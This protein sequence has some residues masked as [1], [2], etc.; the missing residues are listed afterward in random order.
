MP[1]A[2]FGTP[3]QQK[4]IHASIGK[5]RD[6]LVNLTGS[7]R[8][9]N[10]KPSKTGSLTVV[11]PAPA[12][13]LSRRGRWTFRALQPKPSDDDT[14]RP[15]AQ[16]PGFLDVD[17]A[18]AEL[19][20]V[21]RSLYRRSTQAYLDQG[22]SVL[23]LAFGT[24]A[25]RDE[26][27][28]QYQSPLLLVPV[29]LEA[30]TRDLPVLLPT[31]EDTVINPA[32]ALQLEQFGI[33]L[34]AVDQTQA[35]DVALVEMLAKVDTAVGNRAGWEVTPNLVL[36]CFSFAKEA[37]YQDLK[38]NE[39]R[40]A[41]HPA[42]GAL[43]CGGTE[44]EGTEF[45]FDEIRDTEIDHRAA[46]EDTHVIM[47]AD[48]SQRACVAAALSGRSFVMDG[49]PGTGKSQT[50]ANM[51]G[52]LLHAGK[53]VL[54]VSEKA[55]ALD[56]VRDRLDEAG[57]RPYLFEL[58][59]KK[60][61]RKEVA[62]ELGRALDTELV[63]PAS[64]AL[65]ELDAVRR[66]RE[67]LNAYADAMNRQRV[68]LGLSLHDVLGTIAQLSDVPT[69]PAPG[70]VIEHLTVDTLG[71]IGST[72][73][74]LAAAW[75]PALQGLSFLWR[76]LTHDGPMDSLLYQAA[77]ALR[78]LRATVQVNGE[79]AS[80]AELTHPRQ[81]QRLA[82]LLD[83]LS[84]RPA[85]L[86]DNWITAPS[87]EPVTE[88][89]NALDACLTDIAAREAD[90][91]HQ[92]G[93]PWVRIPPPAVL[94]EITDLRGLTP[95]IDIDHLD[96][97]QLTAL[98]ASLSSSAAMLEHR[99]TSLAAL[100]RTLGLNDP[101]D[102]ATARDLL[103]VGLLAEAPQ[104]PERRWLSPSG[105]N[106]VS[107]ALDVLRRARDA[108]AA[109]ETAATRYFT[110]AALG[111]DVASL[112]ERFAARHGLSKL[113]SDYR[114]DKRLLASLS[115]EG[116]SNDIARQHLP[117]AVEWKNAAAAFDAAEA[118]HSA[119]IGEYYDGRSTDFDAA[120]SA[121]EIARAAL[122]LT[123]DRGQGQGQ[124]QDLG[125]VAEHLSRQTAPLA[126]VL[127]M[128]HGI[129]ADLNAW[130][131]ALAPGQAELLGGSIGHAIGWL[132]DQCSALPAIAA[133]TET[134]STAA[135][136]PLTFAQARHLVLLRDRA[137]AAHSWLDERATGFSDT[138]S[139]L[140]DGPRTDIAAVRA[141]IEWARVLRGRFPA[142]G[143]LTPA[144]VKAT[145][146]AIRTDNL[147]AAADAWQRARAV[148]LAAFSG[149]RGIEL[150]A[151]LDDY[152]EARGLIEAL[153]ED[154]GGPGEWHAYQRALGTLYGHGLDVTVAFCIAER[155]PADQLAAVIQRALLQEWAEHQLR[156]DPGLRT[157]RAQDRDVLV[158]EYRKLDRALISAATGQI[159][160]ACNSRRPKT[161]IGEA[162]VIRREAE[163]KK[164]HMPVRTLIEKTR[165]V[166][167]AIKPCFMMSPLS[168][169]QFLPHDMRFNVVIFDEASQ[170]SP[171]DAINCVYR[172]DAL[173]LA[174]DQK[175]LPPTSFFAAAAPDDG[176]EWSEDSAD[177]A[178]FESVLDLAKS[179]GVF[180]NLTLRWHY[181]SR[182]E[183]LIAFSNVSFYSGRLVTFPGARADGPDVGV[184]LFHVEG[185]YRRGSTR[186]N[187]AE[188]AAVAERVIHHFDT[189]PGM[190]L[191][192]VTF[193]EAQ[194]TAVDTVL[195]EARATRPDL[196]RF[197]DSDDRLN[198]FF[199]K[200]LETVQGD[201]RDVLIFSVG[202]GPDENGKITMNFGPLN[203]Q[204]GWRRLNV[205]ITRA[206]YRNEVVSS[207]RAGDIPESVTSPGIRHLRRYLDYAERGMAAL[208][209]E[210]GPGG[211]AESPFEESVIAVIRSWGYD[212]MPQVGTA[213]YRIDIGV[214][215]PGS[216]GAYA[217]GVE[218]DGYHYHSSRAARDRDRLREQVLRG[219]GWR[220]HRIWGTAW[221]R[222]RKGAEHQLRTAIE[223]AIAAPV[224]GLLTDTTPGPVPRDRPIVE[225]TAATFEEIPS[226]TRPYVIVG[227]PPLPN[228]MDPGD[229]G[230]R[231]NMIEP[232][233]SIVETEGPVHI[234]VLH[235]RLRAAWNIG[236]VGPRIR[237]NIDAA[238]RNANVIR[239][240]DF[241]TDSGPLPVIVRTPVRGCQREI[242]HIHDRELEEALMRL[243]RDAGSISREDLTTAVARIYGWSRRGPDISARMNE[244]IRR[245][246]NTGT[247]SGDEYALTVTRK[248]S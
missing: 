164:R 179:S 233:R 231:F 132:R 106:D 16:A 239:Q 223:E 126:G 37:M 82:D 244:L 12:E 195:R 130:Q 235:E 75:R 215:H 178:D 31:D 32:L 232:I 148:L 187:P 213:G 191:G 23:Y 49:P 73:T 117:L 200:N 167:Q 90:A 157:T 172:G 188:A 192:V 44:S 169:S 230:T 41:R 25:W 26:S 48:S 53:T 36:S 197:F 13:V 145:A 225:A 79:L 190:S 87:L 18:P 47:D 14:F 112:M 135:Q 156:T 61:T 209:L 143:P 144:Q 40:I 8:L 205:A 116:V 125:R 158:A 24:L 173:I 141:A 122:L 114:T 227:V 153:Q 139:E 121:L 119:L 2:S 198:G 204:G 1:K 171:G 236:R 208:A 22:L 104:L 220:L 222:D 217:I 245:L 4:T 128:A 57:L 86:P 202:Y 38:E 5:W 211:D 102:F 137:D 224:R 150:A 81:A 180:R 196:D 94:P 183:A 168:V 219:L 203:P 93:V 65:T 246:L 163:K 138:F 10:F 146:A 88:A 155:V 56:V 241:L 247:L 7:N 182:H 83:H 206:H 240:G 221:Y 185:V 77:S 60:A 58:H 50:I 99:R 248:T 74:T 33:F 89:A 175:Q 161:D 63:P 124:G 149:D 55:A 19:A 151:E 131:A 15:P 242:A 113:A 20:T 103:T 45:A 174:G 64:I 66:R 165:T 70:I 123:Q 212:V 59:S 177:T 152:D 98:N 34:P 140:Y 97:S 228:W 62:A 142:T 159:I 54:F 129:Q 210:T 6:G 69:A 107:H 80:A 120:V 189:R 42:I 111:E 108:L 134:V 238:I 17:R 95:A 3:S 186:D 226:W 43:A 193:S 199:I 84:A 52:A 9:L 28:K 162:A 176:D 136:R 154:S 127:T 243:T 234:S 105:A 101:A 30:K 237:E 218:C 216:P 71:E 29:R 214:R 39:Q 11:R 91:T 207:I 96:T 170:V 100:A 85:G 133:F 115:T 181:R 46:P 68:P 67:E 147:A 118:K 76:E 21:L 27:G 110:L 160:R 92:A 229:M 51:I 194:A 78:T 184:E 72:V 109:A 201:E 166:T 35:E